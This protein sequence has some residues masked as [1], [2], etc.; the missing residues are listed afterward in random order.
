MLTAM[1]FVLC[2]SVL[3]VCV[4]SY[5]VLVGILALYTTFKEKGIFAV[6][7]QKDG[8]VT[9]TWQASSEMKNYIDNN[10]VV[11]ENLVANEVGRLYNTLNAGKKENE[12]CVECKI[13]G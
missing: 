6:A 2:I 1:H 5:F 3:I 4:G 13:A 9:K 11:V 10:G 12:N 8:T 7:Y